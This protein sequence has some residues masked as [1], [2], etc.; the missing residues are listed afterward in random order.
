VLQ[1]TFNINIAAQ[2][3][4]ST[5]ETQIEFAMVDQVDFAGIDVYLKSHGLNDTSL[6]AEKRAKKYN[7]N[8]PKVAATAGATND[9]E[10]DQNGNEDDDD[11]ETELQKAERML[12]DEEDELEEDYVDEED[13]DGSSGGEDYESGNEEARESFDDEQEYD[14]EGMSMTG[15]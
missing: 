8:A 5:E 2:E 1:R 12:Q 7:V 11:D 9:V 3:P 4:G 15:R 14:E 13:D 10:A 6:A